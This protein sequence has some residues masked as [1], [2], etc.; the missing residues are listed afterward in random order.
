MELENIVE[1]YIQNNDSAAL[2]EREEELNE[3]YLIDAVLDNTRDL[4]LLDSSRANQTD[5]KEQ[6]YIE[7]LVS[8]KHE[9]ILETYVQSGNMA[10]QNEI[11]KE[12]LETY[13]QNINKA[14]RMNEEELHVE[15]LLS[16]NFEKR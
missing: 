2:A 15:K 7:K 8:S 14:K 5:H 13:V 9:K 4:Y 11:R 6:V 16:T 3:I 10:E 1:T 12:T